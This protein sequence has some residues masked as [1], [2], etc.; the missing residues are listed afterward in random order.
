MKIERLRAHLRDLRNLRAED[1]VKA[2]ALVVTRELGYEYFSYGAH[3]PALGS[4]QIVS[5]FPTAWQKRY[6]AR[7]YYQIDPTIAHAAENTEALFWRDIKGLDDDRAPS[8]RRLL[9]EAQVLGL[10]YGVSQPVHAPGAEW[11]LLNLGNEQPLADENTIDVLQL[12][13]F[14]QSI[15]MAIRGIRAEAIDT[16]LDNSQLTDREVECLRWTAK[17]KTA[18]ETSRI[19]G[20]SESTVTFHLKN[21]I[22]KMGCA[23]RPHAVAKA[24]AQGRIT[25]Y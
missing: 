24:V 3:F 22:S 17:G 19:I 16:E 10:K 1:E 2:R 23:N 13:N 20:V 9:A 25:L 15:H 14:A 7:N 5:C 4:M 12:A 6:C 11:G 18:W 21:A 8:V